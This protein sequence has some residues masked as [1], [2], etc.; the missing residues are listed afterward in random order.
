MYDECSWKPI[1]C[2]ARIARCEFSTRDR[3]SPSIKFGDAQ[4]NGESSVGRVGFEWLRS[5]PEIHLSS[6]VSGTRDTIIR[7]REETGLFLRK[8][9]ETL[10]A[11]NFYVSLRKR[12]LIDD[13]FLPRNRWEQKNDRMF[14]GR[15]VKVF[16]HFWKT[17]R[18]SNNQIKFYKI[19]N[20]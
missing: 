18:K 4:G 13:F 12:I 7:F 14:N 8:G 5:S 15:I 19:P 9:R 10:A 11:T 16:Q 2:D 20:S 1:R 3:A 6:C 17:A